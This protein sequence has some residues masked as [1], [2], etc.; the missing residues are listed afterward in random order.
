MFVQK[1]SKR[2][3]KEIRI[4]SERTMRSERENNV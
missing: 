3:E 4:S 2:I 1:T